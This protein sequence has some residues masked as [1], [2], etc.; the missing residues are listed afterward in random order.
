MTTDGCRGATMTLRMS[1]QKERKTSPPRTITAI[2]EAR[3]HASSHRSL[4]GI[5]C[6]SDQGVL[7]LEGRLRTFFHKQ[8]A[9]EIVAKIEGV[10]QV[11]NRIEVS[12][13][14]PFTRE[15]SKC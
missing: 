11:V 8:L 1:N 7:V 2:A 12:G 3:L 5:S 4:R 10:K 6:K 9:Q 13:L 15:L 14:G